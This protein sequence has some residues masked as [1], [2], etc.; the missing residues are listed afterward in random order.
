[1]APWSRLGLFLD[2]LARLRRE[3]GVSAAFRM[4][5]GKLY[6]RAETLLYEFRPTG[7]DPG[8]PTGWT[9]RKLT[10]GADPAEEWLRRSGGEL[11]LHL[12]RRGA[13]AYVMFIGNEPVAHSWHYP[14]Y[15]LARRLGPGVAYFGQSFV[16]PEWRGQGINGRLIAHMAGQLPAGGRAVME[17]EFSN[18]AS[19]RSKARLGCV[20]VGRLRTLVLCA[21]VV[22]IRIDPWPPVDAP[23]PGQGVDKPGIKP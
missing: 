8:L 10:S 19:Q 15:F 5:R 18:V 6:E 13:V 1:M 3:G 14:N 23:R 2:D 4:V 22:S 17:V 11:N 12:F 9:V 20:L 16:R 21:R 7:I